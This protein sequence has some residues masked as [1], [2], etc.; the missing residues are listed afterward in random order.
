MENSTNLDGFFT[1]ADEVPMHEVIFQNMIKCYFSGCNKEFH[2]NIC[3]KEKLS[4][5]N[6]RQQSGCHG[7][8]LRHLGC[9]GIPLARMFVQRERGERGWVRDVVQ[10][11]VGFVTEGFSDCQ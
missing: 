2:A 4:D 5:R 6:T 11:Y 7:N 10:I 9:G 3:G 1:F 8:G